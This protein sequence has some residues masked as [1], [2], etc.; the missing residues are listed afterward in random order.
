MVKQKNLRESFNGWVFLDKP[1]GI[2]SNKALQR[3]RKLFFGCKAGYVGTLDPLA[4]GFLPIALGKT[5]KFIKFLEN[6]HKE[7]ISLVTWGIKTSTGDQEG[8]IVEEKKNYPDKE[9][10]KSNLKLFIGKMKQIPPKYSAIKIN[11]ERAY[12]LVR[13]GEDFTIKPRS[14]DIF[15]FKLKNFQNK[16]KSEFYVKV[17]S[18]TYIRT[19]MEDLARSM[20]TL[21]HL[22]S[23]RRIGVGNL[24]KKLI[25]L[26][27]LEH[28]MHIDKLVNVLKPTDEIFKGVKTFSLNEN[29]A[30]LINNGMKILKNDKKKS[31]NTF[32]IAKYKEQLVV[33]GFINNGYFWPN[34]IMNVNFKSRE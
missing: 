34:T 30:R 19:L 21:A 7:Y 14:V 18:G 6:T 27:S 12:K 15:E 24:D 4:S 17:S 33:A 26:D 16:K 31:C 10:I 13:K 11:G 3:V 8:N 32:A 29:E 25:S 1:K 5:T 2:S 22:Y 20:G 9:T 23:L 28:M